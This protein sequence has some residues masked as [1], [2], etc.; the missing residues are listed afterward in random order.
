MSNKF[1]GARLVAVSAATLGVLALTRPAVAY[2]TA[3]DEPRFNTKQPVNW[4]SSQIEYRLNDQ[5]PSAIGMDDMIA[6]MTRATAA[7]AAPACSRLQFSSNGVTSQPAS[8]G[9]HINTVQWLFSGWEDHGFPPD[10]PGATDLLY[11]KGADGRWRIVEADLYLNAS[12]RGWVLESPVPD[13]KWDLLSVLTHEFGHVAGLA[14]PCE[15]VSTP[16]APLCDS[17]ASS[18][19]VTMYPLYN[20]EQ[21]S[22]ASDDVA[23]ICFLYPVADCGASCPSDMFC[24]ANGCVPR[25]GESVCAKGETCQ[26]G[27][28]APPAPML[29]CSS[30]HDPSCPPTC[31]ADADCERGSVCAAGGCLRRSALGDPCM[32]PA[33][34]LTSTCSDQGACAPGCTSDKEC[35]TGT[36]CKKQGSG[37]KVCEGPAL[38]FGATCGSADD[39]IGGQCLEGLTPQPT[40][41]RLCGDDLPQAPSCPA[42]WACRSIDDRQVCTPPRQA[43]GGCQAAPGGTASGRLP[44]AS[45]LVLLVVGRRRRKRPGG[46]MAEARRA[47]APAAENRLRD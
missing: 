15:L 3:G 18:T 28:C 41:T 16:G 46:E 47:L 34:C 31:K 33:D 20:P 6:L 5:V 9:D 13:G 4:A 30:A 8:S 32:Q 42:G 45:L 19:E 2:R 14:H 23:G 1:V 44:V 26:D 40:C 24:S 12:A 27:V 21:S 11:E 37:A 25:C 7:W 17:S 38:P 29:P 39:C 43:A 35:S 10:S 36:T 22:L